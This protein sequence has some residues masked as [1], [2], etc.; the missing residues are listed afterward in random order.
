MTPPVR[1]GSSLKLATAGD[2][3]YTI[4]C[5]RWTIRVLMTSS[6]LDCLYSM[7]EKWSF[8]GGLF[9]ACFM[10]AFRSDDAV[11]CMAKPVGGLGRLQVERLADEPGQ[12]VV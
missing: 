7:C 11:V 1:V 8:E 6:A 12:G 10:I 9:P 5:R 3:V 2:W 4:Y